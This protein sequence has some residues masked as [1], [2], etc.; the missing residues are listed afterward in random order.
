MTIQGLNRPFGVNFLTNTFQFG[1][2]ENNI[3]YAADAY[4]LY[5][6]TGDTTLRDAAVS[7][8]QWTFGVNPWDISWVSGVGY[9]YP[10]HLQPA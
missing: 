4:R 8:V 2:N 6:L 1:I 5:E 9:K 3:S 7:T 10:G